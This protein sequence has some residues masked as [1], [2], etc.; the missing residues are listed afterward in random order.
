MQVLI[1]SSDSGRDDASA[2]TLR[3]QGYEVVEAPQGDL[4]Q[5]LVGA[6]HDLI[7][8]NFDRPGPEIVT[9][10]TRVREHAP[11]ASILIL[12]TGSSADQRVRAL[13][14]GADDCLSRPFDAI[15]FHARVRALLRR[16][17]D[18]VIQIGGLTW[19]WQHR[20][21]EVAAKPLALSRNE[22]MLIEALLKS[23]SQI[24]PMESLVRQIEAGGGP[25]ANN[26][27][28]VYISRLRKKLVAADVRI[29]SASGLGYSIDIA[30]SPSLVTR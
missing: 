26:R 29:R 10:L 21:G 19:N 16:G 12:L 20:Q 11:I 14:A 2:R 13:D 9:T 30:T 18:D 28:Y 24:V 17:H 27:L 23:P 7:I 3:D 15:E 5:T 25:L 4:E 1:F 22:T 8:L 6:T